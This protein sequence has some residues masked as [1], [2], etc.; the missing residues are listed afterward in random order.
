MIKVIFVPQNIVFEGEE[1]LKLL[2]AGR[3]A[4]TDIRFGCASCRCGTCGVKVD[5]TRGELSPMKTEER[6]LLKRMSLPLDGSVRLACQARVL[7]GEIRVDL[8]FQ[9]EYDPDQ[10]D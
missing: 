6:D 4:Q 7:S 3:K 1:G 10:G 5:T 9:N 2:V 8:G